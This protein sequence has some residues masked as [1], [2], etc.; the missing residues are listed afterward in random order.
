MI[1][2]DGAQL[3][4]CMGACNEIFLL[5][6]GQNASLLKESGV[7]VRGLLHAKNEN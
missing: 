5:L 1:V 6:S 4:A 3:S 2:Q 7:F